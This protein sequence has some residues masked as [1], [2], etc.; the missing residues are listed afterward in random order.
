[1]VFDYQ[2]INL[3]F[4]KELLSNHFKRNAFFKKILV[5]GFLTLGVAAFISSIFFF[6]PRAEKE[7]KIVLGDASLVSKQKTKELFENPYLKKDKE[8]R[9]NILL[10]GVPGPPWPAPYLTDSIDVLS[11]WQNKIY[12]IGLPRDLLVKI[13]KTEYATK[14]NVLYSIGGIEMIQEKVEEITALKIQYFAVLNLKSMEKIIDA[15]GGIDIEAIEDIYDPNFPTKNRGIETFQI[16]KGRHHLS[17]K[18]AIK[19]L[20]TRNSPEGDFGRMKRQKEVFEKVAQ[21]IQDENFS[22][23]K[24]ISLFELFFKDIK[25][26]ISP[27]EIYALSQLGENF[28]AKKMNY[29]I[30]DGGKKDSPLSFGKTILGSNIASVLWPKEGQFNYQKIQKE[31]KN[32][33]NLK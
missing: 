1:M 7:K 22:F 21:K 18:E 13:P 28:D 12:L 26:N 32:F 5:F 20:R 4:Q 16:E 11:I 15:V 10:L 24:I 14:I 6:A 19:Y 9:I 17:G 3:R 25:T 27:K 23:S 29:F 31:I 30:L 33:L 8:G 2:K